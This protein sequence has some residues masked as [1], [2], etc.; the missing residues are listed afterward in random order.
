MNIGVIGT[1][2]IARTNVAALMRTGRVNITALC[3]RTGQKAKDFA[4]DLS[5]DVPIYTDYM[6]MLDKEKLDASLICTPHAQHSDQFIACAKHGLNVMIEKPLATAGDECRQIIAARDRYGIRAA[7]CHTQRYLPQLRLA[8]KLMTEQAAIWGKLRHICDTVNIHYFHDK[9]PAWFFDPV[10]A[11]AGLL[12]THG[13]HQLDRVHLLSGCQ[14]SLVFASIEALAAYPGLDSGYQIM[15][16]AG[17]ISYC[18]SCAGYQ[19]PHTSDIRLD[20]ERCSMQIVLFSNG[21]EEEGV[22]LG[23]RDGYRCV[24]N[25]FEQEDAYLTQFTAMLD[26]LEGKPSD[27]PTLEEAAAVNFTL[28]AAMRSSSQGKAQGVGS[29]QSP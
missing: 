3:N 13:S 20:F 2:L 24:E 26:L 6:T 5:L 10:Q 29:C 1:G 9:R 8:R 15:G 23:D 7:V 19:V 22:W 11:G 4:R 25:P 18:V 28:D 12:L 27:A 16:T 17:S 21:L 14:S